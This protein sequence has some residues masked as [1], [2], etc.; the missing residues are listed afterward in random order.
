M[1]KLLILSGKGGTGKTTTAAAFAAFSG[2]RAL[3]DC[4]VD[5]PNRQLVLGRAETPVVSEFLGG[6]KAHI[7]A[8]LCD[9]CGLCKDH[10]RFHA[11]EETNGGYAVNEFACEGCGVCA[12]VC[13]KMAVNLSTDVA[14]EKQLYRGDGVFSTARLKMGRGNSGKLVAEVK[15]DL[16]RNAG[17]ADLAILDGSPGIGC[18]VI[19]SVSGVDLILIVAEPSR[20][21]LSDLM[22]LMK[23]ARGLHVGLCVAVNKWDVSPDTTRAIEDLCRAE[24]VPFVGRVPYDGEL[25]KAARGEGS[26]ESLDSPGKQALYAVYENTMKLL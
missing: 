9:R 12:W 15:R 26:M 20:S 5:A 3:A 21:G 11:I 6:D 13:P 17:D 22:R 10:C 24:D 14:G 18:P 1:K 7:D 16:Y 19:A 4:D 2:A 23:T 25:A 8:D